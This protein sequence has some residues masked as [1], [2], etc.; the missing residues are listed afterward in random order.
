MSSSQ[1]KTSLFSRFDLNFIPLKILLLRFFSIESPPIFL[2]PSSPAEE[3]DVGSSISSGGDQRVLAVL[4]CQALNSISSHFKVFFSSIS[5]VAEL[6]HFT[7]HLPQSILPCCWI[8]SAS[9]RCEAK[10]KSAGKYSWA[11]AFVE[12][13]KNE[14]ET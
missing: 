12:I 1:L 2:D 5:S 13:T 11:R 14:V 3:T 8:F 7:V 9:E 10:L 4:L 6:H